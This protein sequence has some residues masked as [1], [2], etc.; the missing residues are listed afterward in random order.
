MKKII[1]RPVNSNMF[2]RKLA[3]TTM[4]QVAEVTAA[5][6]ACISNVLIIKYVEF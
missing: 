6:A 2:V 3:L 4:Y 1:K 5:Q